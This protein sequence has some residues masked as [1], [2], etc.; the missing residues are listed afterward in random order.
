MTTESVSHSIRL[1]TVEDF[2]KLWLRSIPYLPLFHF[3]VHQKWSW[4]NF[5]EVIPKCFLVMLVNCVSQ[6]ME[7]NILN[8]SF[9]EAHQFY[10]KIDTISMTTAPPSSL[11]MTTRHR[12]VVKMVFFSEL[13]DTQR[14][15]YFS[16]FFQC[17]Y[18]LISNR[19]QIIHIIFLLLNPGCLFYDKFWNRSIRNT[20]W[21]SYDYL[22]S[23]LDSE[24]QSTQT[25]HSNHG[26]WERKG[27]YFCISEHG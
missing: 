18:F 6:F 22:T 4:E 1:Y 20:P 12:S 3:T 23:R 10:I 21:S 8:E 5:L 7:N 15:V 13:T 2:H 27:W 16:E 19:L 11:L 17:L 14:Q 24:T 9:W 26:D 25:R